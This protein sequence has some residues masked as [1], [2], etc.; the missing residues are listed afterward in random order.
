MIIHKE[1][2]IKE[3]DNRISDVIDVNGEKEDKVVLW[4]FDSMI[5]YCLW[6]GKDELGN[7][8]PE[9]TENDLEFLYG[10]MSEMILK[11]LN[12]IE[13]YFNII[14]C[15]IFI[16]GKSN[17]RKE[18]YP[19]YKANRPEKHPLT[20]YLYDYVIQNHGAIES[21]NCEAEDSVAQ[22][23][24][25]LNHQGLILY[26][27]HDL[28]ELP[29]LMYN[30]QKEIFSKIDEKQSVYN[31]YK[32]LCLS[33]PGDNVKTTPGIG[34]IY[35]QKNFKIDFTLEQYEEALWT[36]YLKAWKND[37]IKAK[38]QLNLAKEILLLKY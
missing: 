7:P 18:I 2:E 11:H 24:N 22:A 26:V 25:K 36:A 31:T 1:E 4:D 17:F 13:T 38:E 33:E 32:K 14:G 35:F 20:N 10:K 8:N 5:Y 34:K 27:D 16:R 9:Y 21:L 3:H 37:E 19:D 30:Y 23:S 6:S 12:T 15:Y 29:S 28:E